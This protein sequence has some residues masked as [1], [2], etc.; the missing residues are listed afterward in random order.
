M[1]IRPDPEGLV[2]AR[3]A[4]MFNCLRRSKIL[5]D[6]FVYF[7]IFFIKKKLKNL[8]N[9]GYTLLKTQVKLIFSLCFDWMCA[10]K[11]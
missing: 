11:G 7:F 10:L 4:E 5:L 1:I 6:I 3:G 2:W 8:N 9:C